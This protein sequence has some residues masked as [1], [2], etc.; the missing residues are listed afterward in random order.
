MFEAHQ[1]GRG[2]QKTTEETEKK[3]SRRRLITHLPPLVLFPE[4]KSYFRRISSILSRLH[5]KKQ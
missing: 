2:S 1:T 4:R 5:V 3:N